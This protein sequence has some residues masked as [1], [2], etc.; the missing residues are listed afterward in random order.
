MFIISNLGYTQPES[1]GRICFHFIDQC[2]TS[3]TPYKV[4]IIDN[5]G[6]CFQL[7]VKYCFDYFMPNYAFHIKIND[8]N[9]YDYEK[10]YYTPI[11]KTDT[12]FLR[13]IMR[14]K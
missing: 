13:N 6:N 1:K 11:P 3:V 8:V 14:C 10:T 12:I 2:G 5:K 7:S 4:E 9:Y